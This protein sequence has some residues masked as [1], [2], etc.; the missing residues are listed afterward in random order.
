MAR[1]VGASAE[2]DVEAAFAASR[3]VRAPAF[4]RYVRL[5]R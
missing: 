2:L 3:V 5:V 1:A 4:C